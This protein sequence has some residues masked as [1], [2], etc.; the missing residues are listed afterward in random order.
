MRDMAIGYEIK[1][2]GLSSKSTP[3]SILGVLK[4]IS[5]EPWGFS[6]KN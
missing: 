3:L 2:I 4:R 6:F 5:F 1:K